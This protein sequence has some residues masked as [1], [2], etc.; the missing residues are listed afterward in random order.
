MGGVPWWS[1]VWDLVL[2]LPWPGVQSPVGELRSYKAQ[3]TG[4]TKI[5][6][7][8]GLWKEKPYNEILSVSKR[9]VSVWNSWTYMIFLFFFYSCDKHFLRSDVYCAILVTKTKWKMSIVHYDVRGCFLGKTGWPFHGGL[10]TPRICS[11]WSA[12]PLPIPLFVFWQHHAACRIL[13]P[14][15]ETEPGPSSETAES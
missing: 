6:H 10:G 4:K 13:V 11:H 2:S 3:S 15:S 1:S 9:T 5:Q 8:L 7:T 14:Q 12:P